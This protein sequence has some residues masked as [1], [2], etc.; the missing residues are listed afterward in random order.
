MAPSRLKAKGATRLIGA[1]IVTFP[2]W[3]AM[4]SSNHRIHADARTS[5]A[6]G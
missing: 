1:G 4:D 3:I 5:A 2:E 6:R